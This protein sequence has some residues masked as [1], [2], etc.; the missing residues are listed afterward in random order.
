LK[1]ALK[2]AGA[3]GRAVRVAPAM[4]TLQGTG[5][6]RLVQRLVSWA[7]PS[8][9]SWAGQLPVVRVPAPGRTVQRQA[10]PAADPLVDQAKQ[11]LATFEAGVYTRKNHTVGVNGKFDVTYAPKAKRMDVTVRVKF[12]YKGAGWT[13]FDRIV[14]AVKFITQAESAWSAKYQLGVVRPPSEV[15]AKA[16]NPVSVKVSVVPVTTNQHFIVRFHKGAGGAQVAGGVTDIYEDDVTPSQ[17]A[18]N[19]V[20]AEGE[21]ERVRRINPSPVLFG[22]DSAAIPADYVP[23]LN[24]LTDYL[25]RIHNP[26][27]VLDLKGFASSVGAA[28]YNK[29]LAERRAKAVEDHLVAAGLTNHSVSHLGIGEVPGG[30]GPEFRKVDI[31]VSIQPGWENTFST[32][33]HEFGHMLGLGDEY[34]GKKNTVATHHG[35]VAKHFGNEY[36]DQTVKRGDVG[37]AAVM[38]FGEDVRIHH[39]VTMWDALARAT[40]AAPVPVPPLAHDDWKLLE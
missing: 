31:D 38:H 26:P 6:N 5:G 36:A 39:Y 34:Q 40:A 12:D 37:S 14:S 20:T 19:P 3:G 35:L 32:I 7:R 22:H 30:H 21:L 25:K 29:R 27:F 28:D 4:A 13:F 1:S 33:P 17:K 16:L 15:W 11:D 9:S 23:K 18:F 8:P 10:P 2:A 24:F